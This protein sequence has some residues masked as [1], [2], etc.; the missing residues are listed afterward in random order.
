MAGRPFLG[1]GGAAAG[2]TAAIGLW[3]TRWAASELCLSSHQGA[4][5]MRQG[6]PMT[7]LNFT[8]FVKAPS[9]NTATPGALTQQLG[10]HSAQSR[11]PFSSVFSQS[12]GLLGFQLLR[13]VEC[14]AGPGDAY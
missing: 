14:A 3:L 7:F 9:P 1:G 5:P 4:H 13:P 6:P 10:A 8:T 12:R 11:W 2:G